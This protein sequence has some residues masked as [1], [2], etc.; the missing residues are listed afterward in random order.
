M[1][2]ISQYVFSNLI[3]VQGQNPDIYI[4]DY[5]TL[6]SAFAYQSD[7]IGWIDLY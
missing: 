4:D 6:Y 7:D 1:A 5:G 3:T 2:N